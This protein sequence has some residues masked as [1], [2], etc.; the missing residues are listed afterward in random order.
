MIFTAVNSSAIN[1]IA[2]DSSTQKL[3]IEFKQGSI[4]EYANVSESVYR[5][6]MSA[7]SHGTYFDRF[8]RPIYTHRRIH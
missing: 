3:Q 4:Y 8:I 1:A 2:Y 5:N 7:S 6:F